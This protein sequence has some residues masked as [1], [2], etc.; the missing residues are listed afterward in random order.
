MSSPTSD[1]LRLRC[2]QDNR[3]TVVISPIRDRS[4]RYTRLQ[5]SLAFCIS[6]P[7]KFIAAGSGRGRQLQMLVEGSYFIN[8][9]FATVEMV[10][11]AMI[12]VGHVGW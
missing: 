9:L 4:N 8:R 12:E 1:G 7:E 3:M 6:T 10:A 2:G 11:K 5:A